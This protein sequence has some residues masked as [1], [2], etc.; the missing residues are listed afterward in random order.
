MLRLEYYNYGA[1]RFSQYKYIKI[2]N[3]ITK[4]KQIKILKSL[5]RFQTVKKMNE[6]LKANKHKIFKEIEN[7]ANEYLN[8]LQLKRNLSELFSQSNANQYEELEQLKNWRQQNSKKILKEQQEKY[9][10]QY[11]FEKEQKELEQEVKKQRILQSKLMRNNIDN[12]SNNNS[13]QENSSSVENIKNNYFNTAQRLQSNSLSYNKNSSLQQPSIIGQFLK[14]E[15]SPASIFTQQR[16]Q[17]QVNAQ[18]GYGIIINPKSI[19]VP[20]SNSNNINLNKIL[21]IQPFCMLAGLP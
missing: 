7:S 21:Q 19:N 14:K 5:R 6:D 13:K 17:S 2:I 10:H 3:K 4:L 12:I 8:K 15:M 16:N 20:F 9:M 18:S 1:G 11:Q